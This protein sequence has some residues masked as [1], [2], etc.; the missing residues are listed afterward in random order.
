MSLAARLAEAL[1]EPRLAG[2]LETIGAPFVER[3]EGDAS[4]RVMA[5]STLRGVARA[6]VANAE[7]ARL[8]AAR[9]QL[10][11][12]L[13]ATR[14]PE[15]ELE[16]RAAA[17]RGPDG[18]SPDLEEA[19]DAMRLLRR[20]ETL[21]AACLHLADVVP[22]AAVSRFLS[23]LAETILERSL[24]LAARDTTATSSIGVLGMGKIG[25]REFTY[26]SDLDLLFLY[27]GGADDVTRASRVG[28]R[29]VAY[30][31]T[32][33]RVG[34]AY[35]VDTRLRPSGNQGLLV[36]SYDAFDA[37]QREQARLWEHLVLMR[38]RAI[39]G[40][41]AH[42]GERLRRVRDAVL[43]TEVAPWPGVADMRERVE[44]ER[45]DESG[46][47]IAWKTGPGGMMD[48]DFLASGGFLERGLDAMAPEAPCNAAL[49]RSV[50]GGS[51]VEALLDAY[52]A[53]REIEARARFA[54]GRAIEALD[55]A[56]EAFVLTA[57]LFGLGECEALR[58]RAE[59]AR[60]KIRAGFTRVIEAGT[61]RALI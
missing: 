2:R 53:L 38:A 59:A 32:M 58:A 57:A 40:D 56:S 22:F 45:A 55:P 27:Q 52:D 29:L 24:A 49:L 19:L 34:V 50:A 5:A 23:T 61:I 39:A 36:T 16:E 7:S 1:D 31:T 30:L 4:L 37:Y 25:G 9:P 12:R 20:E 35:A 51:R 28:Q 10:L 18:E 13:A 26:H 17:L 60:R 3:R 8:L 11:E 15:R 46:G 47:A 33:T 6:V 14:E 48:V 54:S 44:R 21:F 42:A 43:R 41:R